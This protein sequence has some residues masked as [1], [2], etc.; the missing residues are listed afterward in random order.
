MLISMDQSYN[1]NNLLDVTEMGYTS[2]SHSTIS[3]TVLVDSGNNDPEAEINEHSGIGNSDDTSNLQS[4]TVST[5]VM[6][7]IVFISSSSSSS[8]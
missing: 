8:A 1:T 7:R 3:R 5:L 2:G 6:L 4:L